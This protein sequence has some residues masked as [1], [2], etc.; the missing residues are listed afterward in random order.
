MGGP[1]FRILRL[2]TKR[3]FGVLKF[4]GSDET[5]VVP[6]PLS[7]QLPP[8]TSAFDVSA[9]ANYKVCPLSKEH[10]GVMQFVCIASAHNL[11]LRKSPAALARSHE[12]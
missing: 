11:V 3:I 6:L 8:G 10:R 5:S 12:R 2:G 7:Y 1:T 4:D 9:Y